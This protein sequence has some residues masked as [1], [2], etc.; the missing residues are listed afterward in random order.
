MC[1][2]PS[3]ANA[4]LCTEYVCVGQTGSFGKKLLKEFNM[5]F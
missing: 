1:A 5:M 3:L 4:V 2:L